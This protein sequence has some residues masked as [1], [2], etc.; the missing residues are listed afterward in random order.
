MPECLKINVIMKVLSL[1]FLSE[2]PT[3]NQ[4]KHSDLSYLQKHLVILAFLTYKLL[5]YWNL[6]IASTYLAIV[7][8]IAKITKI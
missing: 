8:L 5:H 4:M 6:L 3:N 2:L 7:T 1:I